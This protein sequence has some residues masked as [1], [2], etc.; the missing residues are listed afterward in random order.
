MMELR[1]LGFDQKQ[2]TRQYKFDGVANGQP[3]LH[4]VVTA[5]LA[6]FREHRIG[7]QEGPSLCAHKLSSAQQATT[8]VKLELTGDDLRAHADARSL[9]EARKAEARRV[10]VRRRPAV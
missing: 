4:Y 8:E 5:D 1:Y 6:L 10:G 3:T 7:I 2:N 9:A